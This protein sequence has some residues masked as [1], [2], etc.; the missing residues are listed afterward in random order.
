VGLRH[1]LGH[2]LVSDGTGRFAWLMGRAQA[3]SG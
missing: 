2:A 1:G 3:E